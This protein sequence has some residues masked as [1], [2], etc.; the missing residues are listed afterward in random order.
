MTTPHPKP[1][2]PSIPSIHAPRYI[3]HYGNIKGRGVRTWRHTL[4]YIRT[5]KDDGLA[6]VTRVEDIYA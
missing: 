4:D 6:A 1:E 2:R 5:I 3:C